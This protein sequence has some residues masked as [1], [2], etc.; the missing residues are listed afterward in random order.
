MKNK[1]VTAAT[2]H[3]TNKAWDDGRVARSTANSVVVVGG[4][5]GPALTSFVDDFAKGDDGGLEF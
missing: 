2:S 4:A 1:T 3:V 5:A